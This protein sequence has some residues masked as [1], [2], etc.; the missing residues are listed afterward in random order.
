MASMLG[1]IAKKKS[2]RGISSPPP[3]VPPPYRPQTLTLWIQ[4]TQPFVPRPCPHQTQTI[5]AMP[6]TKKLGARAKV[7]HT[8][9]KGKFS[10]R[11]TNPM[12]DMTMRGTGTGVGNPIKN[13]NCTKPARHGSRGVLILPSTTYSTDPSSLNC[14]TLMKQ[15][16]IDES[17]C[18]FCVS[19]VNCDLDME[20][21]YT[22]CFKF[23]NSNPTQGWWNDDDDFEFV[24]GRTTDDYDVFEVEGAGEQY[25]SIAGNAA[26]NE[27]M[28]N[29]SRT[30][31]SKRGFQMVCYSVQRKKNRLVE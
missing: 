9:N 31:P 24:R 18:Y 16:H 25:I 11:N 2:L 14:T 1:Y 8:R 23:R 6:R 27:L 29:G 13:P 7:V 19:D 30:L 12:N 21:H 4:P 28:A 26:I 3:L 20:T 17:R 10:T 15:C 22:L 5:Y